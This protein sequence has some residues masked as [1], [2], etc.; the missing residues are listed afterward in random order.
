[1][2]YLAFGVP[3]IIAGQLILRAGLSSTAIGYCVATVCVA[4]IGLIAQSAVARRAPAADAV[5]LGPDD[6]SGFVPGW[7]GCLPPNT[8]SETGC[9]PD[10]ESL[11]A[12]VEATRS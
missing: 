5:E 1:V 12:H 2:A 3:V 10:A 7:P 8:S 6:N 9:A 4:T 11:A